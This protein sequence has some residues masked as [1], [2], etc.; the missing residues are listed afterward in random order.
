MGQDRT[1]PGHVESRL[2]G[3]L[4]GVIGLGSPLEDDLVGGADDVEISNATARFAFD[5]LVDPL[6]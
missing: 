3:Q 2:E 5:G 1:T 6:G 4:L